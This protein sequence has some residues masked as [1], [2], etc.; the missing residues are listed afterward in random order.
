MVEVDGVGV[1]DVV[2]ICCQGV[3]VLVKFAGIQ[4]GV[5]ET[6]DD[7]GDGVGGG[8]LE[9]ASSAHQVQGKCPLSVLIEVES[10][11]HGAR[12]VGPAATTPPT[13]RVSF[14]GVVEVVG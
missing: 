9:S 8:R 7:E 4:G 5:I 14:G 10:A 2:A 6:A 1:E 11:P 13:G 12:T 3:D